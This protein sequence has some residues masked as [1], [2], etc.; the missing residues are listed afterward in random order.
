MTRVFGILRKDRL[1]LNASKCTFNLGK[2][3]GHILSRREIEAN[4]DQVATLI[5]LAKPWNAKQVQ[6]LTEMVAALQRFISR[7]TDKC[8]QFFRLLGRKRKFLW[9]DECSVA[10]QGIKSYLSSAPC[11]SIPV[12]VE[13]LFLYL[14]VSN[15]AISVVLVQEEG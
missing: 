6:H 12:P 13:P 3:L 9:D 10:F 11:L 1:W 7:S 8:K 5:D 15:Q 4:L 2:F 14:A